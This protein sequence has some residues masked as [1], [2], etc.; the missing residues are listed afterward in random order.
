M[1]LKAGNGSRREVNPDSRR[2]F[3]SEAGMANNTRSA[4]F[5]I[6]KLILIPSLLTL[7]VTILRLVGELQHW[8]TLLFNPAAGGGGAL[9][10]ISWLPLFFGPYFARRLMKAGQAPSTCNR[11]IAY[12]VLG[13]LLFFAGSYVGFGT[14]TFNLARDLAGYLLMVAAVI[15]LFLFWRSLAKT[16]LAYA[17]AARIPVAVIMFF[18][19]RGSWGTHYDAVPPDVPVPAGLFASFLAIGLAPQ[20]VFWVAYTVIVGGLLGSIFA[21]IPARRRAPISTGEPR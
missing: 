14:E 6:G 17:Y 13:L 18:A 2:D 15:P 1:G 16:L 10:G 21:A 11:A 12:A 19:I 20:L 3:A 5:S 7:A 9:V 4:E 8:P